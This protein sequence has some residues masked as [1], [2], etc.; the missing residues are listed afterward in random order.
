VLC[1]LCGVSFGPDPDKPPPPTPATRDQAYQSYSG[2]GPRKTVGPLRWG[3][4]VW[5]ADQGRPRQTPAGAARRRRP[6]SPLGPACER[7]PRCK[8]RGHSAPGTLG[9]RR[10][11]HNAQQ[12]VAAGKRMSVPAMARRVPP[13][14]SRRSG[15][16]SGRA[17]R[18]SE[19]DRE[20]VKPTSEGGGLLRCRPCCPARS[21]RSA[22][23][24]SGSQ[25]GRWSVCALPARGNQR[26]RWSMCPAA[27]P[28][29]AQAGVAGHGTAKRRTSLRGYL[30][31]ARSQST[32]AALRCRRRCPSRSLLSGANALPLT[33]KRGDG[34]GGRG[35]GGDARAGCH[36]SQ[37]R[38]LP[39]E[40]SPWCQW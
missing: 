7:R 33:Q 18:S 3:S 15:A 20:G 37:N 32:A 2:Q 26:S 9:D 5:Q 36:T 13:L 40:R 27:N 23:R 10:A 14:A 21:S 11:T 35:R 30:A 28:V 29:K 25:G 38:R 31:S 6:Q 17:A 16:R 39:P 4:G 22:A 19:A 1:R 24:P 34:H 12:G 8:P